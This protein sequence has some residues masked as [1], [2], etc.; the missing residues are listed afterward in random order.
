MSKAIIN[1]GEKILNYMKDL[2][3]Y[4]KLKE[5]YDEQ[6]EKM[7][8]LDK[9]LNGEVNKLTTPQLKR[10][11]HTRTML[12]QRMYSTEQLMAYYGKHLN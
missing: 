7:E 2:N 5:I 3:E 1:L 11:Y 6:K 10:L 4:D 12:Q 8:K 9:R